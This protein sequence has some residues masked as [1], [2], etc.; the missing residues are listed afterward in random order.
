MELSQHGWKQ[1]LI[2]SIF[3]RNQQMVTHSD[4]RLKLVIAGS[5]QPS[6]FKNSQVRFPVLQLVRKILQCTRGSLSE[7]IQRRQFSRSGKGTR[8]LCGLHK[9][10]FETWTSAGLVSWMVGTVKCD[11]SARYVKSGRFL[12]KSTYFLKCLKQAVMGLSAQTS[13]ILESNFSFVKHG[14]VHLQSRYG[15]MPHNLFSFSNGSQHQYTNKCMS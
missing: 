3:S 7:I 14:T 9:R 4:A 13:L 10:A 12:S 8:L 5:N 2:F 6:V 15:Y 1:Q 11:C